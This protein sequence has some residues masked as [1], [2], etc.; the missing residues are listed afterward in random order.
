[1]M[2][3]SSGAAAQ[4][5]A[6]AS[7]RVAAAQAV[8]RATLAAKMPEGA[9][10]LSSGQGEMLGSEA[11]ERRAQLWALEG[12]MKGYNESM[13][14]GLSAEAAALG[15]SSGGGGG[16]GAKSGGGQNEG[17]VSDPARLE[18]IA[19]AGRVAERTGVYAIKE[20]V[21]GKRPTVSSLAAHR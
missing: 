6:E 21:I 17:K 7:G 14:W 1:M 19:Q 10:V 15:R 8:E 13:L 5:A 20:G 9:L 12:A 16:G 3:S 2:T 18:R 11:N 4:A